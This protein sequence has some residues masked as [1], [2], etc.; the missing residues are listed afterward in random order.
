MDLDRIHPRVLRNVSI[1]MQSHYNIIFEK[2]CRSRNTP[3]NWKRANVLPT[4]RK[5]LKE[6]PGVYRLISLTSVPVSTVSSSGLPSSRKMK[7][8]WRE[9]SGGLQGW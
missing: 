1:Y 3:D 4:Y 8:Y 9:S 5:D 7:S 2:S 6:D